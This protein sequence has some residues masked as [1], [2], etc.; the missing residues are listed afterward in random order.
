[1]DVI[2]GVLDKL[3]TIHLFKQ[4]LNRDFLTE[5]LAVSFFTMIYLVITEFFSW[6][7]GKH[8]NRHQSK[9]RRNL[10]CIPI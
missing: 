5:C 9:R 2:T 7:K 10:N 8:R 6:D 4:P 3:E 1:M